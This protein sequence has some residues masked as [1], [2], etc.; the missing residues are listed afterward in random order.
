[1]KQF[2]SESKKVLNLMVNSIYTNKEIFLR[3]LISNACD[4]L[5]KIYYISLTNDKIKIK[6][7]QLEINLSF[8]K[9]KRTI[10]ISDNGVGMSEKELEENLGT[11][12]K[13]DSLKFKEEN[14][15]QKDVDI[16]GQFGVGFYSAFMI[17]KKI[18]VYTRR[19]DESNGFVWTSFGE[20]GY[21]IEKV[22]KEEVGTTIILYLKEDLEDEKY[23]EFLDEYK[24]KNMV[25]KYSDYINY[26][27]KMKVE[28]TKL[29]EGSDTEYENIS[30]IETLNSMIPL[31]NKN[32]SKITEE[33]Y[34][35]FYADKFFD[36]EAPQKVIHFKMEGLTNFKALLFI[37]NHVPFD[38]YTK[39][40]K[41]GLQLY[42]NGVLIMDKC[43][44][45]L[46]DY[47]GFIKGIIDTDDLELNISRETLQQNRKLKSIAKNLETKIKKE[48]LDMLEKNYEKYKHLFS[49]F[50]T[51]IKFGVYNNY[52]IDKEKIQDL[53]IFYSK[54]KKDLIT[55]KSYV[56]S[57][58]EKQ[59]KIYYACGETVD[60]IDMLPQVEFLNK[61][62]Y[63]ILYL[64]ENIDEFAI[65]ALMEYE[66]KAFVNISSENLDV[67]TK[68]EKQE[69]SRVNEENKE[70]LEKMED[71]L[72]G[73]VVKVRFTNKLSKHPVCLTTEGNISIEME[74]VINSMPTENKV[75]AEII[76]EINNTHPIANKL[77]E[78]KKENKE[79]FEKYTK[80]LYS[81]ARIIEGLAIENPNEISELVCEMMI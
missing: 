60:K 19:F 38:L 10:T 36:Y 48:L 62:K 5:D 32:K 51:Q 3:E 65:Q 58:K 69:I 43:E 21:T 78:L 20:E 57:M 18:E 28:N 27:I 52:G 33:E 41:K 34:N 49:N 64:T 39:E 8:D 30:E 6:K 4:A 13:S 35:N 61:K 72:K 31:W 54:E 22:K 75:N 80:I 70:M 45:L 14:A 73:K 76:L 68:K 23:S 9:E 37:P 47:Y 46:P 12:A 67:E 24:L 29:K 55:L 7:N 53:L 81:Q 1:M 63:D 16:I 71:I 26:P 2:K 15:N 25:K 56:E 44:E 11:I 17:S 77:K 59:E 40:Y 79:K 74:K 50:G 42:S 66:G